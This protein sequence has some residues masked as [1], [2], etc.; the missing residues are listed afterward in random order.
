MDKRSMDLVATLMGA[1]YCWDK[2]GKFLADEFY[3]ADD[4]MGL[5]DHVLEMLNQAEKR[6]FLGGFEACA[7]LVAKE[8]P[9]KKVDIVLNQINAEREYLEWR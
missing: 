9:E 4:Q 1:K 6:G 3:G 5:F 8:S 2:E 7:K